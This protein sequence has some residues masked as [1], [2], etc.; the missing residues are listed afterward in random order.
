[1]LIDPQVKTTVPTKTL[2][3]GL[4]LNDFNDRIKACIH[5]VIAIRPHEEL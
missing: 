2:M 3:K 4:T 1:M 5:S